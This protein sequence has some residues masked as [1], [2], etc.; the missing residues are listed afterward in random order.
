[1][2]KQLYIECTNTA[3]SGLNTGIQRVVRRVVEQLGSIP[4]SAVTISLVTIKDGNFYYLETLPDLRQSNEPV[5]GL[6]SSKLPPPPTSKLKVKIARLL[7]SARK[8]LLERISWSPLHAFLS[9]P[10]T[11]F[12]LTGIL[13]MLS[14]VGV[15]RALTT[16]INNTIARSKNTSPRPVRFAQGDVLL[17][18]DASSHLPAWGAVRDAKNRRANIIVVIYDLIPITHPQ[19]CEQELT[20]A[21]RQWIKQASTHVDAYIAISKT[22]RQSLQDYLMSLGTQIENER[23]G[24]FYLG[25][26]VATQQQSGR[27]KLR[28]MLSK[29]DSYLIVGTIEPRKNHRYLLDA[30]N[31]LWRQ[32]HRVKLHIVGWVGWKVDKLLHDIEQHPQFNK[33]LFLWHDLDDSEL[34]YCYKHSKSLVFPSYVEGF[35]LPIIEAQH[36]QLPVLASDT[37]IHREVGGDSVIYFDINNPA[38]LAKKIAEVEQGSLLLNEGANFDLMQ[39]TWQNSTRR[40]MQEIQRINAVL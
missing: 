15:Y 34:V 26:D 1:M 30:F 10:R 32:G 12:G 23:L 11:R 5:S 36:Y 19:F 7:R 6:E 20:D 8:V 39:F 13:Y 2:M 29:E 40:L 9:A 21:V 16:I 24:Y 3:T 27:E 25:A 14:L 38:D 28:E 17:M 33:Q 22:V 4:S 35:G 31:E 18:L 37:P